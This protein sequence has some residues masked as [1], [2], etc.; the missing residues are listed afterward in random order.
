MRSRG[1]KS[2]TGLPLSAAVVAELLG[3]DQE[4]GGPMLILSRRLGERVVILGPDGQPLGV[5]LPTAIDSRGHIRL[6]FELPRSYRV[7]REEIVEGM[8]AGTPE[9]PAREGRA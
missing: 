5:V 3:E 4:G 6:G 9:R 7:L 2:L 8:V 1:P